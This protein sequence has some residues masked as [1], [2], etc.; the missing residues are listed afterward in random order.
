MIMS[1]FVQALDASVC[2][3]SMF[4]KF[5]HPK[6]PVMIWYAGILYLFRKKKKKAKRNKFVMDIVNKSLECSLQP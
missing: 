1:H 5:S 6:N 3:G 2:D 4:F